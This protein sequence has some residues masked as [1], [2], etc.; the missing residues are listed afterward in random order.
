VMKGEIW[1]YWNSDPA[2]PQEGQWIELAFPVPV[3]VRTVRLYDPRTGDEAGSS[4]HVA[5]ATVRLYADAAASDLVGS[6]ITSDI[7]V[8]GTDVAFADVPARVVRV[9]L[10]VVSGTFYGLA[11]A[12]LAEIEVI[13]RG[14]AVANDDTIFRDGFDSP[15]QPQP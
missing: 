6:A 9:D 13:A 14:E 3:S 15:Q 10:D 11:I 4:I 12:S 2:Q 5:Q 7:A 1:R 8:T